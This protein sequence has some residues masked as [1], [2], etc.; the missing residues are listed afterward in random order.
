MK[1]AKLG[2]HSLRTYLTVFAV[3]L[4]VA[5]A[6]VLAIVTE[7]AATR[8]LERH[9]G[10]SLALRAQEMADK[11]DRGIYERRQDIQFEARELTEDGMR[12]GAAGLRK[13]L[14]ALRETSASY[15]WIGYA[16]TVGKVLAATG[17]LLEGQNVA[18]RPWFSGAVS[19]AFV[20]DAHRA[21]LLEKHLNPSGGEP[22]RFMDVAMPV[23]GKDGAF[24]GVLGAH[25]DWRWVRDATAATDKGQSTETLIL[26]TAGQVLLGPSD[27]QD[28]ALSLPGAALAQ[29]GFSGYRIERWPDGQTY[30]AGYSLSRGHRNYPGL[31][32]VVIVRE[33]LDHAYA[34]VKVLS[35]KFLIV[36]SAIALLFAGLGWFLAVYISRPLITITNAAYALQQDDTKAAFPIS[37]NFREVGVLSRSLASLVDTLRQRET[38]LAHQARHQSLTNLPNRQ[39]VT[40][41]L[42]QAID[43]A[44]TEGKQLAVMV[45]SLDR[46]NTITDALDNAAGNTALLE[47]LARIRACLDGAAVLGHL[48]K[49]KFVVVFDGRDTVLSRATALAARLQQALAAPVHIGGFDFTLGASFGISVYPANGAHA[50]TLLRHGEAALQQ[51]RA[52]GGNGIEVFKPEAH[53]RIL[54]RLAME[55]DLRQAIERNEFELF[56][57]PQFSFNRNAI[58]GVEALIRWRHP[59]RGMVSPALFIPAAE[60]CGLISPIGD[61]VLK[62]ACAQAQAWREQGLPELTISVNVSAEQ[63]IGGELVRKVSAALAAHGID[64]RQLKLEITESMVMQDVEQAIAVMK[65]LVAF[66][67][68]V[69]LDDFGTG[70]SSLSNL[71]RFPLSELK[72]DQS[73]VRDLGPGTQDAP[74]V[75]TIVALGHKMGLSVIAEGVETA[76]QLDFLLEIGCNAVQGYHIGR[77]MPAA[78]L[79]ERLRNPVDPST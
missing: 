53:A 35:E 25:I 15:A 17:G 71:R 61:W 5:T 19:T 79:A 48:D 56:Y 54:E 23:F 11:L 34:P 16:D 9:I 13:T 30:L 8:Q 73:F 26:S 47:M 52:R 1:N 51:A 31:G 3:V 59:Q 2:L 29:K 40:A 74:I 68:R 37:N 57:Q 27:L 46:F 43:A 62:Q 77:P 72:I 45:F 22:L 44:A 76:A 24:A 38:Q 64:P 41:M 12:E 42:E 32:W 58:V 20:G 60:A 14:N 50:E 49:E 21:L 66:G 39:Y 69:S 18:Q 78:E 75:K 4:T 7:E 28:K 36:G 10:D 67:L 65:E 33:P 6:A 70:Y 55:R 63:F